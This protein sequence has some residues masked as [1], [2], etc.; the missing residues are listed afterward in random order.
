MD[1][2]NLLQDYDDFKKIIWGSLRATSGF[3]RSLF[4]PQLSTIVWNAK[5]DYEEELK[6]LIPEESCLWGFLARGDTLFFQRFIVEKID[7]STRGRIV[8]GLALISFI[9][10]RWEVNLS[11]S[12]KLNRLCIPLW[13]RIDMV[14]QLVSTGTVEAPTGSE[15]EQ[16]VPEGLSDSD[17]E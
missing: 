4:Y 15:T 3:S 7:L 6:A 12:E 8:A 9:A 5:V 2:L 10:D 11:I 16:V 1:L 17:T 13:N 14:R